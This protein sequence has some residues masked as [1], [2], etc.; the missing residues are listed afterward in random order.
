MSVCGEKENEELRG[1]RRI[2]TTSYP[3]EADVV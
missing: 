2:Y 1:F 3:E